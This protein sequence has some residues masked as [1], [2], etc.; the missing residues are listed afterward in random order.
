MQSSRAC[1][2]LCIESQHDVPLVLVNHRDALDAQ[3]DIRATHRNMTHPFPELLR[4]ASDS[5][6]AVANR[7]SYKRLISSTD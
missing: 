2:K 3:V 7:S 6:P 4:A 1:L 5:A